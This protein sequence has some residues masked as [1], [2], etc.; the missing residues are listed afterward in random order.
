[1]K[2]L[3][4]L[5]L[6]G[7]LLVGCKTKKEVK[8]ISTVTIEEVYTDSINIR[9]ITFLDTNTLAFAGTHGTFGTVDLPSKK[10]RSNV[11]KFDSIYP[12]FRAV[13][14][15]STDFFMLS[16]ASP[17]LIYKT[18]GN[19]KMELVYKEEG[20]DVFYDAMLFWNDDEGLAIGDGS[21]GC[22]AIV[23]T[24]NG[25][26]TWSKIDCSELPKLQG[27]VGAYAASNT[28]IEVK[29]DKAWIMTSKEEIVVTNDKGKTWEKIRTPIEIKEQYQGIYSIDFYDENNG[30]GIGGDFS[31]PAL[32]KSNK[33]QTKDG[34][35]T[36]QLVADNAEPGYKSCV[37]YVPNS[38][39]DKL[40]T[41]G[42]T[43]IS[44]SNNGGLGWSTISDE[45]FYT[46]RFLNDSIA[47]AA[48][49]NRIAK[50]TFH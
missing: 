41:V 14:N 38:D 16:V 44:V 19:G 31:K 36:W 42:F 35:Q 7:L 29:G 47:Y 9:A 33:I 17:A 12:E 46:I 26:N 30:Y 37:Q 27:D 48:G 21:N 13:A 25:G 28:N 15:T 45:G 8:P 43:G 22:L 10:I 34:G 3:T 49:K 50:L 32:N 1:M 5:M 4:S 20:E 39:A 40:V 11:Q 24:R 23:I 18:G 6:I 2:L